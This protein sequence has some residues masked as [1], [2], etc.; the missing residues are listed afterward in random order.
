MSKDKIGV[1]MIGYKF[2]GKAHSNAFRQAPVFFDTT[3]TPVLKAICG[4][5]EEG[6]KEAAERYGWEGYETSWEKLVKRDDIDLVD[7]N[8]PNN[9]H[10]EIAIAAAENG[11]H[12][13]LEKPMAM[14]AQEAQE[15]LDAVKKAGV[16]LN[17]DTPGRL[18][19]LY[20]T[21]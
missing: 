4:R 15:M 14:N 21:Q 2:M 18:G 11:K 8:T 3:L 17:E 20:A 16:K 6:V 19:G 12:I 9:S 13:L 1:G 7:I 10:A 5:N